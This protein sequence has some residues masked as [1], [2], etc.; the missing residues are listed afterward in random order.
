MSGDAD[1]KFFNNQTGRMTRSQQPCDMT[2][3]DS[4]GVPVPQGTIHRLDA[5]SK[6]FSGK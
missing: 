6:S 2:T 4:N 5:I 3:R 1:N